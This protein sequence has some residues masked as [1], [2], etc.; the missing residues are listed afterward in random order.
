MSE[1]EI[2]S[3]DENS[4]VLKKVSAVS[5]GEGGAL[6]FIWLIVQLIEWV[7]KTPFI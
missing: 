1:W 3:Q 5:T 6:I 4:I 7:K 2:E